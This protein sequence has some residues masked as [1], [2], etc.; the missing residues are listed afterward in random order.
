MTPGADSNSS[1]IKNT[2][3]V[4][5]AD[6]WVP[7]RD[8]TLTKLLMDSL[9]GSG[10]T[11]MVACVSPAARH[12]EE[13]IA[14]LNYAAR[15]KNIRNRPLVRIDAR[16]KL[17]NTLRQE[18]NLLREEKALLREGKIVSPVNSIKYRDV[19]GGE[20]AYRRGGG[21]A[22]RGREYARERGEGTIDWPDQMAPGG[23]PHLVDRKGGWGDV[24]G[25]EG[26][27]VA[28]GGV[29]VEG[30]KMPASIPLED[31]AEAACQIG[32]A[33]RDVAALLRKYEEEVSVDAL[34]FTALSMSSVGNFHV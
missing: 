24:G 1:N 20:I 33:G 29:R 14:T 31:G 6:I 23:M 8:S 22:A 27:A 30:A 34:G 28:V 26:A 7:Y 16:E 12:A 11:L 15:A 5:P 4:D 2:A 17:I 19:G 3:G 32:Q 9:G 25:G 18:I 13:S 10:L 21:E